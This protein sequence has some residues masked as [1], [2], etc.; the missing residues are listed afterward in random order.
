MSEYI[1]LQMGVKFAESLNT[2]T[3]LCNVL[4]IG[5]Y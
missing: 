2:G 3:K 1:S 5:T 4:N